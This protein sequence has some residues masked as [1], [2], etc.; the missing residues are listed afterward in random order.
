MLGLDI[1]IGEGDVMF[2]TITCRQYDFD[3]IAYVRAQG[4]V[5]DAINAST[6]ANERHLTIRHG[7]QQGIFHG[8]GIW[9]EHIGFILCGAATGSEQSYERK[10]QTKKF[11]RE[12]HLVFLWD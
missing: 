8:L 5:F 9:V 3:S 1:E 11:E 2:Y 10:Q 7:G 12:F 4:R 6:H